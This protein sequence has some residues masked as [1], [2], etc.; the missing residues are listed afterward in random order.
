MLHSV[1]LIF[2]AIAGFGLL[3]LIHELGHFM[4]AKWIKVRVDAF[5]LGFG[6][7]LGRKWGETEYRLSL[8]PLGGYVKLAG[9]EPEPGKEPAPD[10]FYAKTVGQRSLVFVAGVVMNIV[11]GYIIFMAAYGI[12]VPVVP[13]VAGEI[14]SGSAAWRVGL[15]RGDVI[16]G[17]DGISPPIDF[18][19]LRVAVTLSGKGEGVRLAVRRDGRKM[20][21]VMYPE[22]RPELGMR[23]AGIHP[24]ASLTVGAAPRSYEDLPEEGE[25]DAGA[26]FRA[27]LKEGDQIT[28]VKLTGDIE[29]RAVTLPTEL[30]ELLDESGGQPVA[31][32]FSRDGVPQP[33][34]TV[35]P[36]RIDL[37]GNRGLV[38]IEFGSNQI[39]EVRA[40]SWAQLAGLRKED[41][42]AAVNGQPTPSSFLALD[43]IDANAAK[44]MRL[45]IERGEESLD[46]TVPLVPKG[47]PAKASLVFAPRLIV[48][49]LR[50][51]Y[52]AIRAGMQPGDR[53]VSV[54]GVDVGDVPGLHVVLAD[55]RGRTFEIVWL[56]GDRYMSAHVRTQSPW[57]IVVPLEIPRRT[58]RA[59]L[60]DTIRL[61]TRKATQ[62][63]FRIYATLRSLVT[64]NVSA[65][66]LSGPI[67][68]GFLTYS[69]AR[70]GFGTLLYILGV[71]SV[72]L[73]VV[74][75]LPIPVFDGG[76]LL[77]AL[78]EKVRGKAVSEQIR[79]AAG[80]VG[81]AL[82]LAL[83]SV[84][85][86][87]DI[88]RF[89]FS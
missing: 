88:W 75:L 34:V 39:A 37:P 86:W 7:Y 9:E 16:E 60:P 64:G 49:R 87:N 1:Y 51:G 70:R 71:L 46:V 82:I 42:I 74:N 25:R 85:F 27:G 54:D 61:G 33:P 35:T 17:I 57:E 32:G 22:Y 81:L 2:L 62:W 47:E 18:E 77:F 73:G 31:F 58:V 12:G 40:G 52:P 3:V 23:S 30:E 11:T 24:M 14:V 8:I 4:A 63:I 10:E 21:K 50:T 69:A 45:R 66:H 36:N 19:D 38:G 6:P 79:A 67:G 41:R 15:E 48:S 53:V 43:A 28:S 55:A 5:S 83:V 26:I 68:I 76:H 20:T 89:I 65:Q 44:P 78:I 13:A 59:A 56:R 84:T 29:P 80:Y 72:N